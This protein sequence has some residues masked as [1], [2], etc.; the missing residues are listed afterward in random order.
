MYADKDVFKE[1]FR[2]H[3]KDRQHHIR[4]A[5]QNKAEW[6]KLNES[7]FRCNLEQCM[8]DYQELGNM[9]LNNYIIS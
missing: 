6:R 1:D 7:Y 3:G 2:A 8:D 4:K 9:F 5:M